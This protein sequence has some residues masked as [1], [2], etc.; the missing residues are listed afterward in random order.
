MASADGTI[1]AV[2]RL[3]MAITDRNHAKM[4]ASMTTD[5]VFEDTDPRPNGTRIVGNEAIAE[6]FSGMGPD[7]AFEIEEKF[8]CGDRCVVLWNYHWVREG[9]PGNNRGADIFRV[10]GARVSQKLAYTKNG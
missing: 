6:Y 7:D 10:Q 2:D 3:L 4:V 1:E 8:A 5:C 9:V